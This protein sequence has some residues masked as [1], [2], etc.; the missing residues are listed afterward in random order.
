MNE[1]EN[2]RIPP[3]IPGDLMGRNG[4][5]MSGYGAGFDAAIALDLPVKFHLW[6]QDQEEP[7]YAYLSDDDE[8]SVNLPN[9][10]KKVMST[11]ELYQ[12]WRDN[13]LKIE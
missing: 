13:I 9:T 2:L 1:L 11:E 4:A 10:D 3:S 8:W 12:Y 7:A 6:T 5:Y